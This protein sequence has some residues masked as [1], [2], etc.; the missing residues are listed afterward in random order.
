MDALDLSDRD[1]A[2]RRLA[3]THI[4][5]SACPLVGGGKVTLLTSGAD[6]LDAIFDAITDAREQLHMEY[7]EMANV[8]W[9]GQRLFDLLL[10]KLEA[11]VRVVLSY[12][13]EGSSGTDSDLFDRL[14]E[15][16][17]VLL[18]FH[19]FNPFSRR[20]NPLDLNDRDHRK[21]LIADGRV[22][23]VGGVNM[24]RVYENPRSAGAPDDPMNA[25]WFDAAARIEGPPVA[26]IQRLFLY[27]WRHQGGKR[28]PGDRDYPPLAASGDELIRTDGS[29]PRQSR[30]LYFESLKAAL[31]SARSH[32]LLA[33]GYFVPTF[34]QWRLFAEA[35]ERGVEVDLLLAGYTD[36]PSCTRAARALYGRLLTRGVRIHEMN[37]G[38][39]HA[40]VSTIDGVWS[41]IGSS[42]LDRR[43][44]V[45]NNEVD[46]IVLG[47]STA[48]A[49]ETMLRGWL[50]QAT[51]IT[52]DAWRA[53]SFEER[54]SEL[55]TRFW[56]RYM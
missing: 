52:L 8:H 4:P 25:F 2:L 41:A 29:A 12:D 17:A 26:E 33:T 11:G 55:L 56:S 37:D 35:A 49:V 48:T 13:A 47:R 40:K 15:A 36:V 14:R 10:A 20:F 18:K 54:A 51:P 5:V 44:F 24:A 39:L 27:N 9:R 46:A 23:F 21:I 32:V 22:A 42:N 28:L 19:P 43:S 7:Y 3:R 50:A 1:E 6:A 53:R 30:Q 34:R 31:A 38:V 45:Y 16:G